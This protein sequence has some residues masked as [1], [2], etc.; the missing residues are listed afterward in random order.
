MIERLQNI[1]Y[2]YN[3]LNDELMKPENISNLDFYLE[4]LDRQG[5][6]VNENPSVGIILYSSI[7]TY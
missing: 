3:E 6:K 5:K 2:R 4:A 7:R 1:E